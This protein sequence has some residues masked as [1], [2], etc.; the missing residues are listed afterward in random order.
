MNDE[1]TASDLLSD[2]RHLAEV[3]KDAQQPVRAILVAQ[4]FLIIQKIAASEGK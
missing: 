3:A 4:I 2:L 1:Y